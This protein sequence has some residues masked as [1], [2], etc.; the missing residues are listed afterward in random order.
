M[1][2][3]KL[4]ICL[5]D[6]D[7]DR[8]DAYI[9]S[10]LCNEGGTWER[11]GEPREPYY[12]AEYQLIPEPKSYTADELEALRYTFLGDFL[13]ESSRTPEVRD[14]TYWLKEREIK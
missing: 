8:Q 4:G 13:K 2:N 5:K 11:V 6:I 12:I 7:L 10:V 1:S 14:F 3:R 9:A